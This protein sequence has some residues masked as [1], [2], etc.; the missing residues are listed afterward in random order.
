M[1]E[2]IREN[3]IFVI[4]YAAVL[5]SDGCSRY[6]HI[7]Q[8]FK[9]QTVSLC[10]VYVLKRVYVYAYLFFSLRATSTR[11]HYIALRRFGCCSADVHKQRC[12]RTALCE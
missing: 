7:I 10:L 4:R 8:L 2:L 5:H 12:M 1:D 6:I 9:K 3:T 11:S